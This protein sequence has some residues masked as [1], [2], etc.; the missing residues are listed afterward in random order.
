MKKSELRTLI[1]EEL[2]KLNEGGHIKM[3]GGLLFAD[4]DLLNSI[5]KLHIG[6]DHM[7]GGDFYTREPLDVPGVGKVTM[8]FLRNGQDVTGFVGRAHTVGMRDE[9]GLVKNNKSHFV[10]LAK[11]F[12]QKGLI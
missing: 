9:D 2:G 12:K 1:R 4:S 7:G 6:L 5:N 11:L 3:V 8:T 10:A